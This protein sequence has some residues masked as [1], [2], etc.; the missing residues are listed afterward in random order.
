MSGV[1]KRSRVVRFE[2]PA[3]PEQREAK[4]H[5]KKVDREAEEEQLHDPEQEDP[6]LESSSNDS[7]GDEM[8][9]EIDEEGESKGGLDFAGAFSAILSEPLRV[10]SAPVLAKNQGFAAEL[11]KRKI[12]ASVERKISDARRAMREQW[13]KTPD[14]HE[15]IDAERALKKVATSGVVKLFNAINNQQKQQT[16]ATPSSDRA[17]RSLQSLTRESFLGALKNAKV[18]TRPSAAPASGAAWLK[19]DFDPEEEER[20]NAAPDQIRFEEDED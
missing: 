9:G 16:S 12:E 8:D 6:F 13:K 20:D 17:A 11:K 1:K 3:E 7:S 2:A 10:A 14:P 4:K 19:D 18:K 15:S 5:A